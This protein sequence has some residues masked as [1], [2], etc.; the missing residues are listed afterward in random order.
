MK[1]AS[2]FRAQ[3]LSELE[4]NALQLRKQLFELKNKRGMGQLEK[5]HELKSTKREI[6]QILTVINEKKRAS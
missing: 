4:A 5:T 3:A 6:A 1:K 2:E